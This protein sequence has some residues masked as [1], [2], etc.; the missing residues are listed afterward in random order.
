LS[1][2]EFRDGWSLRADRVR[3]LEQARLDLADHL[4]LV[5][6]LSDTAAHARGQSLVAELRTVFGTFSGMG[7]PVYIDYYRPGARARLV[8]GSDWRVRPTDELLKRLRCILG[9]DAVRVSYE[10][11]GINRSAGIIPESPPRLALVE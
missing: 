10:R 5:L 1:F 2:D 7:L 6:D 4:S 9:D 11:G 3:T 8:L